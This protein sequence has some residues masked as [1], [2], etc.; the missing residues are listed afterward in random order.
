MVI[1]TIII[2]DLYCAISTNMINWTL[3]EEELKTLD[4]Q[5]LRNDRIIRFH[6]PAPKKGVER[7]KKIS[8]YRV[9]HN[10]KSSDSLKMFFFNTHRMR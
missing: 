5:V 1:I 4:I 7:N 3:H 6:A 10:Y 9:L 2:R 8:P